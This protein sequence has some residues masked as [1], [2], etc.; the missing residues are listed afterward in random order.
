MEDDDE[1][2][3]EAAVES[4]EG[5]D[6]TNNAEGTVAWQQAAMTKKGQKN[7]KKKSEGVFFSVKPH[8]NPPHSSVDIQK[9]SLYNLRSSCG[10]E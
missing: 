8:K 9:G 4:P 1:E 5:I 7:K 6:S 3:E 10:S 2:E